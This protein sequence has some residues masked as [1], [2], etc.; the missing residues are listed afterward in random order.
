MAKQV[1]RHDITDSLYIY[2]QDNSKRWYARFVLDNVWYSKA[3]KQKEQDKAIVKAIEILTEY[4][5]MLSNNIPILQPK[6][7]KHH[8]FTN[9]ADLAIARMEDELKNGTGKGIFK[10]YIGMINN[11]HKPFFKNTPIKKIDRQLLSEFDTWRVEKLGKVPSK[12]TVI[13]N[14]VALGRVFDEAII[15]KIITAS[16]K[17]ALKSSGQSGKRRAA[18][19]KREYKTLLAGA[20]KAMKE[21]R[22]PKSKNIKQLLYYYIQFATLTGMRPGKEIDY[23]TWGDIHKRIIKGKKYTSVTVTKGKTTKFTGTREIICKDELI[24]I[25]NKF[26]EI[27]Q[28]TGKDDLIFTLPD[29][30]VT[31]ELGRNFKWLLEEL[32]LKQSPHGERTLYSLRHTY[33]TWELENGTNIRVIAT[34]CGTSQQMIEQHYSHVVP[35]AFAE[36]LSGKKVDTDL[37]KSV[38]YENTGTLVMRDGVIVVEK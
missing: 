23:L 2:K 4:R 36:Q 26:K 11:Y 32:N 34:Q 37:T 29:G 25:I 7:Q 17:P 27:Q 3:T 15:R 24:N 35:S 8:T 14:N 18:F 16:E 5:I 20:V 38:N 31:K 28:H 6:K 21:G 9:V 30:K 19:T 12:S 33:I 22:T 10:H 13:A 1:E